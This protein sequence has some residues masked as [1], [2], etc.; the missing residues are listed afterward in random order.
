MTERPTLNGGSGWAL[1]P[2]CFYLNLPYLN[3]FH[4]RKLAIFKGIYIVI[5]LARLATVR[6]LHCLR[7]NLDV[8]V[9]P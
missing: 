5:T 6:S 4:L 8:N 2:E 9:L 7:I 3:L 1:N